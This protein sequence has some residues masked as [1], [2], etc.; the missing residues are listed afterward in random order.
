MYLA[1]VIQEGGEIRAVMPQET[2]RLGAQFLF[3]GDDSLVSWKWYKR[4]CKR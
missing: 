3:M 2:N 1:Q 4:Q